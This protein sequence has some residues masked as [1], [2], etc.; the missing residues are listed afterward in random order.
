MI[1]LPKLKNPPKPKMV[2]L[3]K[4]STPIFVAN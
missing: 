2:K 1:P 3:P 4:L